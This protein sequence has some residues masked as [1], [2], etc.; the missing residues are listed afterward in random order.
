MSQIVKGTGKRRRS[1]KRPA[2][3]VRARS[4]Q[5][6]NPRV[7]RVLFEN[8]CEE[9]GSVASH[10][11]TTQYKSTKYCNRCGPRCAFCT[12]IRLP[13]ISPPNPRFA[14]LRTF[15]EEMFRLMVGLGVVS[16]ATLRDWVG[17]LPTTT[18]VDGVLEAA[19]VKMKKLSTELK[20]EDVLMCSTHASEKYRLPITLLLHMDQLP[21]PDELLRA[22]RLARSGK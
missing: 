7:R 18:S 20:D 5:L 9:C 1:P 8:Q 15:S 16:E 10:T 3:Y 17:G 22:F 4:R 2:T 6:I 14:L 13:P 19:A 11:W 21:T 12:A